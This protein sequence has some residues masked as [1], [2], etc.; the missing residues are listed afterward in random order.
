MLHLRLHTPTLSATRHTY[1]HSHAYTD[2]D[3]ATPRIMRIDQNKAPTY[4]PLA[5]HLAN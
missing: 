5:A 2:S 3:H 1:S 4:I